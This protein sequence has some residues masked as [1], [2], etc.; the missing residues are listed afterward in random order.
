MVWFK[1]QP[2]EF[3]K[4]KSIKRKKEKVLKTE[5]ISTFAPKITKIND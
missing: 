3:I 2:E 5:D 1:D 4:N